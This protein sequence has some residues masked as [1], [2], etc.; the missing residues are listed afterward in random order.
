ML[1]GLLMF[2]RLP[3]ILV[4]PGL[5]A[6]ATIANACG[7]VEPS[8]SQKKDHSDIIFRGT[9]VELRDAGLVSV[10]DPYL[11]LTNRRRIAVFHVTRVWKG[12]VGRTF[13]MPAVEETSMCIGF[14]PPYL[15]VGSDLLVYATRQGTPVSGYYTG[16]CGY[17]KL[18]KDAGTDLR[19]LGPGEQPGRKN[20][21][22]K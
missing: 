12:E 15:K 2:P 1:R 7:C 11:T 5:I 13:E 9:I 19:A 6:T 8:V 20:E 18:A 22:K 4:L 3:T 14:W 21:G 17:H 10:G 16:I